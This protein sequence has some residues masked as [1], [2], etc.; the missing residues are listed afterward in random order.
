MDQSIPKWIKLADEIF[1]CLKSGG[2]WE[3]AHLNITKKQALDLIEQ[4]AVYTVFVYE[5]GMISVQFSD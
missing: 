1:V 4:G 5:T 2:N 3:T